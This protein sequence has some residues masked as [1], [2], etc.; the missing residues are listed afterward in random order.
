MVKGI[1]PKDVLGFFVQIE[2]GEFFEIN[3]MKNININ[4]GWVTDNG[5]PP[6]KEI[7]DQVAIKVRAWLHEQGLE[8]SLEFIKNKEGKDISSIKLIKPEEWSVEE[9]RNFCNQVAAYVYTLCTPE[10]Y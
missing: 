3:N 10:G 4:L 1:T 6:P 2:A 8:G 7:V 9:V 5:E